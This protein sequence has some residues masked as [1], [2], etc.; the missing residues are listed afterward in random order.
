MTDTRF[1]Y[2]YGRAHREVYNIGGKYIHK[3]HNPHIDI[4]LSPAPCRASRFAVRAALPSG[5]SCTACSSSLTYN[6]STSP[7]S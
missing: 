1:D 6:P 5:A 7:P 4:T 2:E 3:A